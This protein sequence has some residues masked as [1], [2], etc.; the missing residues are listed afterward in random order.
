M[1]ALS[2]TD[3]MVGLKTAVKTCR[4]V[5]GTACDALA[6]IFNS[7]ANTDKLVLQVLFVSY[8]IMKLS[9]VYLC[10]WKIFIFYKC[11][12]CVV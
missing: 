6:A 10:P 7:S 4:E 12:Q 5:V 9:E 11:K 3:V 8:T 2:Q 1:S